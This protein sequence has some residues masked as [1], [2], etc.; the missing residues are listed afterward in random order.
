M[1]KHDSWYIPKLNVIAD[2]PFSMTVPFSV[3]M[4][5]LSVGVKMQYIFSFEMDSTFV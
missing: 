5:P 2:I 1:G 4:D 3:K